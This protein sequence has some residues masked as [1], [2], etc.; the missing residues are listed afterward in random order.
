MT[1]TTQPQV[2]GAGIGRALSYL[3]PACSALIAPHA[4]VLDTG[5]QLRPRVQLRADRAGTPEQQF[6]AAVADLLQMV[7]ASGMRGR[8]LRLVLS[9]FWA[10]PMLLA[11]PGQVPDDDETDVLLQGQYRRTYGEL[12]QGWR[13]CWTRQAT[14]LLAVA[15]PGAGLRALG[16]GLALRGWVLERAR[17]LA[18]DVARHTGGRG[19]SAW[20][21][22]VER[23]SASCVRQQDGVWIEWIVG[24][25]DQD[26][27]ASLPL[28][29][30]RENAR[31]GDTCRSAT[32][33]D[34]D[35]KAD[36]NLIR[37]TLVDSGWALRVQPVN[38]AGAG[39]AWR[40]SRQIA[41][42]AMA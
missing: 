19:S 1:R 8:R 28:L 22:I 31:R 7:D 25:A 11:L 39:Q 4:V 18:I 27:G 17:P 38:E 36:M 10:R 5:G 14:Q 20:L 41:A 6:S 34:L 16:E 35:G 3:R 29:L 42:G 2:P 15:W 9:D 26:T 30:E 13:I 40:L 33:I 24:R 23:H 32:I 21:V 37:K 12:M